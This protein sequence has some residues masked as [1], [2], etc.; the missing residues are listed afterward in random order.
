MI[1]KSANRKEDE[2]PVNT[3]SNNQF[4]DPRVFCFVFQMSILYE[5]IA[6]R[7]DRKNI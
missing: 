7:A 5:A 1:S 4:E 2:S 3:M 6:V